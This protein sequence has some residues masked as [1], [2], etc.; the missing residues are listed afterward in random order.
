MSRFSNVAIV[1]GTHGNEFSGIYAL[2][3]WQSNP[4][5]TAR[6]SFSTEHVF[7]NP[8]AYSANKRY[9]DCDLNRQF[10]PKLLADYSLANYEQS[11]AKALN[12]QL[13]PKGD[14]RVDFIID[15]HNT[16]SNMGPTLILL[17]LDMFN[18]QLAA[19]I[20]ERM[21]DAIILVEDHIEP[22]QH[23]FL[24]SI[25]KQGVIVEVGPQP[26]SVLRHDVME[27]MQEMTT[28]ILDFVHLFNIDK[29]PALPKSI[30]A[31]RYKE[32]LHLPQNAH[33]ERIGMV[34][35]HVQDKDFQPI[36][37]GEPLFMCFDGTELTWQGDY[38]AY[39]HFINE[40]AYYDNNIAMSM[41][42]VF[43]L[44]V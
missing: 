27:S 41:A 35:Q 28:H 1:G 39:P 15:L 32:T 44:T 20:S 18:K 33:G 16:T 21:P 42:N 2:K 5:I 38:T 37:P 25:G 6:D 8:S 26:Q 7:A 22:I 13:G 43:T 11:R 12:Q 29:V 40:A 17:T 10:D 23:A 3:Q 9:V 24:C 34:H 31:Y 14:P 36:Q 30:T 19:Y 4:A